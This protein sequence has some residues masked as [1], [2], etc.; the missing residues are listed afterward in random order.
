MSPTKKVL[1][2][3]VATLLVIAASV[4]AGLFLTRPGLG[5]ITPGDT[6]DFGG[7]EWLVLD[8]NGGNALIISEAIIEHR[9]YNYSFT[10]TTWEESSL[11]RWLNDDFYHRFAADERRRI[12]ETHIAND[13]PWFDAGSTNAT[14]DKIF[15]LSI[16]EIVRYFGDSGELGSK[17]DGRWWFSDPYDYARMAY[18]VNGNVSWW[19]SR[20][21]GNH[22]NLAAFVFTNGGIYMLGT[23]VSDTSGGVRPALWL[24][25]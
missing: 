15:L 3:V 24:S 25:P 1:F 4:L 18:D 16:D 6:I 21:S 5:D 19:W 13:N 14:T 23:A 7:H 10:S 9:A 20:S 22:D 12:S 17:P 11:R 2:A 8:I